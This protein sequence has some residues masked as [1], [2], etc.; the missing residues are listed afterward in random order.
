MAKGITW[1][2]YSDGTVKIM[3]DDVVEVGKLNSVDDAL[4]FGDRIDLL[5]G[6]AYVEGRSNG[7]L[8]ASIATT[9]IGVIGIL[10]GMKH[11][12]KPL[13]IFDGKIEAA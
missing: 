12:K 8:L 6:H 5:L 11:R 10:W 7:V 2:C 1:K 13:N 3:I 9:A 4:K